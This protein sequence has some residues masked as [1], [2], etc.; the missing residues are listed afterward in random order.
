MVQLIHLLDSKL[1][2]THDP[3]EFYSREAAL[4]NAL[5]LYVSDL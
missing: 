5:E 4:E 3:A 2:E 1:N